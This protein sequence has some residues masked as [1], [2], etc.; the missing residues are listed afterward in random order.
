MVIE[1]QIQN[2]WRTLAIIMGMGVSMCSAQTNVSEAQEKRLV[3]LSDKT[4]SFYYKDGDSLEY[5]SNLFSEELVAFINANSSTLTAPLDTLKQACEIIT[6]P[7]GALRI[8]SWNTWM[9]GTMRDYKN[10]YQYKSNGKVHVYYP[11]YGEEDIG[12]YYTGIYTLTTKD[13][14]YYLTVN[15]GS[16]SSKDHYEAI[17][18]NA[19]EGMYLNDTV[20]L[21]K[22]NSGLTHSISFEYDFS[23][24]VNRPERPL[25]LIKYNANEKTIYIPVVL[26]DGKVTNR[27]IEYRFNGEYFE[28]VKK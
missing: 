8:Y 4:F 10:L 7:D 17:N 3:W 1:N 26:E 25:Q 11:D 23:T 15:G 14:I 19:I 16:F 13:K 20:A 12:T 21:I 18:I 27:F 6:S 22:T 28:R 9:G 5:Y 24:V 2:L